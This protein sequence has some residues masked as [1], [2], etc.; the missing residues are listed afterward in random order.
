[1]YTTAAAIASLHLKRERER[2]RERTQNSKVVGR[3]VSR[4]CLNI[5]A[6]QFHILLL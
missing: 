6:A 1:M 4:P 2:E 3:S 5:S